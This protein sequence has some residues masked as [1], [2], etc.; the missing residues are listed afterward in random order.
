MIK[1]FNAQLRDNDPID[2]ALEIKSMTHQIDATSVKVYIALITFIKYLYPTYL[3][4]LE[5]TK[6]GHQMKLLNFETL[7]EKIAEH[8]K[9]FGEKTTQ[10]NVEIIFLA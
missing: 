3:H 8:E 7:V 2:L 4:Y 5:S 9:A 6:V 10:S 1:L